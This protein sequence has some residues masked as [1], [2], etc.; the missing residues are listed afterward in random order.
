MPSRAP[1]TRLC[2]G[3]LIGLA[4]LALLGAPAPAAAQAQGGSVVVRRGV[5]VDPARATLYM[6]RPGGGVVALDVASGR[7]SWVAEAATQPLQLAG[8]VLVAIADRPSAGTTDASVD[9]MLLN[10]RD[11]R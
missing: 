4:S 10:A 8:N 1:A 7:A 3:F 6:M 2:A 5:V 9:V 11:G